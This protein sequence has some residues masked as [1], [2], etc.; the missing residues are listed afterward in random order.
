MLIKKSTPRGNQNICR[1][2]TQNFPIPLCIKKKKKVHTLSIR[3]CREQCIPADRSVGVLVMWEFNHRC[4]WRFW[5][6]V[7]STSE[8]G[9][10][11]GAAENLSFHFLTSPSLCTEI[12]NTSH[13]HTQW[14]THTHKDTHTHAHMPTHN[15]HVTYSIINTSVHRF[16]AIGKVY[17][18]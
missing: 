9:F 16:T 1:R 7:C 3:S 4:E 18:I 2:E 6:S 5:G 14:Y 10:C 17:H 15:I 11:I 8:D 12:T 13:T